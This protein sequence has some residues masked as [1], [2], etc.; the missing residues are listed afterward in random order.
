MW[1]HPN[2]LKIKE[3]LQLMGSFSI[4][5]VKNGFIVF[6]LSLEKKI[7]KPCLNVNFVSKIIFMFYKIYKVTIY[8]FISFKLSYTFKYINV[9]L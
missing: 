1:D 8:N 5:Y 3:E 6:V 9:F 4:Y 7:R 2:I